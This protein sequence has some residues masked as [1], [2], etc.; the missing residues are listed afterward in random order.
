[1]YHPFRYNARLMMSVVL[2]VVLTLSSGTAHA[3]TAF[4]QAVA[5][6]AARDAD[7]AAF[8][9]ENGYEPVW[10][11]P[12][13]MDRARRKA[14][15]EALARVDDHALPAARYDADGLVSMMANARS[16]R[17]LG[18]VEVA[19][20]KAFLEYG[21]DVSSGMLIPK[22]IDS[23]IVREIPRKDRKIM[24]QE[25]TASADPRGY[26]RS[27][28]PMTIEYVRLM[29]E[30]LR[31]ERLIASGG[32]GE[33]VPAGKLEPGDRGQRVVA[34]RNRLISMGFMQRSAT[35]TY[36]RA[37][38]QAVEAFQRTNG[39]EVD[40]V[41]GK[42]T[43]QEINRTPEHRLKSIMVA[44]ERERWL[45]RSLEGREILVNLTDFS[46]KIYDDGKMTFRTRSVVGKDQSDRRSPEFSDV[47][48]HMVI[49]PTWNVPRSI[50]TK[51]YLPQLKRNPN[52]VS[53]LRLVD[54]RG[55]TVNRA[56]VNFAQYSARTFP[57][58]MKQSPGNRNAL[59]LVKFMFPNRHNIY[60]HD[61]PQ[62]ALFSREVRAYS[63]GCIRLQQP[64]E[65]AYELLAKQVDNP[66][67]Y[68][69]SRLKTGRETKV[70]LEVN[71]P[72]HI[73]Y[74]TAFTEAKGPVQYRRDVYGRDA[75]IW[76]AMA[77][78]GVVLR[79]YQ[80]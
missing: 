80:G 1:M 59:G 68:F 52:A 30:K 17:D 24:M 51:E 60:L 16:A 44:M 12:G 10:T 29:K 77:N 4:K 72:V 45:D 62:K 3:F 35:A 63:H 66:K 39:L 79:A 41:A 47:M 61:T 15:T 6:S 28:P 25:F 76:D 22:T 9:R 31:L 56:N 7:V 50:A 57:F 43:V 23:D 36:D 64:F 46:A 21:R 73:T 71:I 40:G 69:H 55:R 32:W 18:K 78:E 13:D 49:N 54:S 20:T 38:E 5:E 48:E 33:K 19:L 27:L 2:A 14:L 42:G 11:G 74:R 34:M 70:D 58:D 8:Y 37:L 67:D 26:V 53:Y 65:F 75:K